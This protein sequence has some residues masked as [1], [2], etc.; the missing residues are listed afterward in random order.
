[1]NSLEE[2]IIEAYRDGS[3]LGYIVESFNIPYKRVK[4]ILINLKESSRYKR[5]FTDEFKTIIAER[6]ANGVSR[7]QI[8][9]E[10]EINANTVKRACEQFGNSLKGRAVSDNEFTRIDGAKDMTVCP[11]CKSS[12]VNEVDVKTIYCMSC[13]DEFVFKS[14]KIDKDNYNHYALKVNW[15]YLD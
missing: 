3:E 1:M 7:R 5:T 13:G 9:L 11:S 8:S 14:E 15:E 4:S 6:D 2:R 12:K 10:L